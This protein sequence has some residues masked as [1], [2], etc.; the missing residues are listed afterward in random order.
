MFLNSFIP[1]TTRDWNDLPDEIKKANTMED[2]Q[3]HFSKPAKKPKYFFS[4]TRK[5][6]IMH[7]R[8]RLKCSALRQHLY[9]KGIGN[10]EMCDRGARVESS[11][12][13]L[14]ECPNYLVPRAEMQA[15]LG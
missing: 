3:R 8:L 12:H 9:A 11:H 5:G 4:G 2:F 13:F 10:D 15:E 6:Q 7:T 1:A 14:L